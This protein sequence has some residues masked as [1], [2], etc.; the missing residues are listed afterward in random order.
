[1]QTQKENQDYTKSHHIMR[2]GLIALVVLGFSVI[3]YLAYTNPSLFTASITG[4]GN[5]VTADTDL[6]IADDYQAGAGDSDYI[7]VR[8]GKGM[9]KM[10]RLRITLS[11]PTSQLTF[12]S[13][14]TSIN[15][16]ANQACTTTKD[17]LQGEITVDCGTLSP[18]VDL[19]D[20][21]ILFRVLVTLNSTLTQGNTVVITMEKAITD[22]VIRLEEDGPTGDR[23]PTFTDGKI[24]VA[25]AVNVCSNLDCGSSGYCSNNTC[26]C[27]PGYAGA[28]C[29]VC[30]ETAGYTGYPNCKKSTLGSVAGLVLTLNKESIGRLSPE[31]R[32]K[33]YSGVYIILNSV[34]A[35]NRTLTIDGTDVFIPQPSDLSAPE[36]EQL[37]SIATSLAV[38]IERVAGVRV[39]KYPNVPGL[40]KLEA[41]TGNADMSLDGILSTSNDITIVPSMENLIALGQNESY[42][43]RIIGLDTSGLSSELN[44][45]DVKWQPQ[46]VNRLNDAALK[47]GLLERGEKSGTTPLYAQVEKSTGV[48]V[49]SNQLQIEV[50]SAP[51]IEYLRRLGSNLIERGGRVNLS[52]KVIDTETISDIKDI[53]TSIVRS[54]GTTY[55]TVTADSAAVWFTATP[56]LKEVSMTDSGSQM[57]T[58]NT[59]ENYKIYTIPVEIPQDANMADG[60]YQLVLEITDTSGR[61][62]GALLPINIGSVATGDVNGDGKVTML[63][64]ITAFQISNGAL[65]NPN[66]A[67]IQAADM[68]NDGKVNMLDVISLFNKL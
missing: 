37:H 11:A 19:G 24:T 3:S 26:I 60:N 12:A 20:N 1:M 16:L 39:T 5:S 42:G 49:D 61:V 17:T 34:N 40:M 59:P 7:E 28:R 50:K 54:S 30:D 6:Y 66:Q 46:P 14:D 2:N 62:S 55:K 45:N 63:D 27:D 53:R 44:F 25:S 36:V 35:S 18:K 32:L 22:S 68:N 64:V 51:V 4:G 65:N 58:D 56:F 57:G 23:V 52:V 21:S 38:E 10:E 9:I 31:E 48:T 8:A 29:N 13:A 47:G 15:A 67:Q 33:A 41:I 43:L